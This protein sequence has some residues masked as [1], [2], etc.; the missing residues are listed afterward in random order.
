[1]FDPTNCAI[2]KKESSVTYVYPT[3]FDIYTATT[4]EG[5]C[6]CVCIQNH[7]STANS[8]KDVHMKS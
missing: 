8:T 7:K 4:G 2:N 3:C 1:M 5:R 6:V